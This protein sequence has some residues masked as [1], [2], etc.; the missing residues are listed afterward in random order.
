MMRAAV[1]GAAE[2]S[3][4]TST[5]GILGVTILTSL[6]GPAVGATWGRASVDVQNEV[7]RLAGLARS[8]GAVG[9]VCSGHEAAAVY[10]AHGAAL[11]LLV[12][13]I[14]LSGGV[15]HDQRRVMSPEAASQAGARWLILGRAVT[16]ADD[17]VAAMRAIN[18]ALR[19][20]L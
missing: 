12:P 16:A 19:G 9:I 6:D 8:S 20:A 14:R 3:P 18:E 1:D 4:G 11:G 7:I 10:A 2:G 17:P 5:C 13:G 15:E